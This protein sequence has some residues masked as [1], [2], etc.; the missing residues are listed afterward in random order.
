MRLRCGHG[1][2]VAFLWAVVPALSAQTGSAP[3]AQTQRHIDRVEAGLVPPVIVKGDIHAEH[4]LQERMAALHVP[5]VSIAV[6]HHGAIEWAQGFGVMKVGGP[7]VTAETLFQAGSISKPVAALAAL[8]LVQEGKLSLDADVNTELKSWKLPY[9]PEAKEKSVTLRELLSHTGGT[10]VHGF[11]GYAAGEPVPTLVQVLDGK[12]PANTPPI[13][14]DAEPGTKYNY[15]GGGFTIM[16]QVMID[17]SDEAFPKLLKVMVLT[18]IGMTHSTY[19]QPLPEEW[20]AFAA[21]PYEADGQAVVGGAHTY[22]EMAAAGLWT[23]PT[24]LA[25]YAIELER[26]LQGGANHVLSKEM[27][28]QMLTPGMGEWGLGIEAKG[29]KTDPYFMHAG[30]DAGFESILV[31]Y[32]KGGEGAVVMT[33][34]Q[35]G[36]RLLADEVLRSVAAEYG[37][38][39]F[40]T[41]ERSAVAVSPKILAEYVGTFQLRPNYDLAIALNDGHLTVQAG[42]LSGLVLMPESPTKFFLLDVD[43]EVEFFKDADGRVSHLGL[44]QD[45]EDH[46]A[47]KK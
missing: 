31:A 3:S 33:N 16:Q 18:P 27:T 4:S 28:E 41:V 21:T 20:K 29:S 44:H 11:V 32:E 25:K 40:R 24:D 36:G 14:V 2:A 17:A 43:A 30:I 7:P 47:M 5:G 22:P 46:K 34:A 12:K 15:S 10:T 35:G 42:G 6:I 9:G 19:Q 1:L 23:T 26:S 37:W 8:K 13:R 45:G 38:P 39:D